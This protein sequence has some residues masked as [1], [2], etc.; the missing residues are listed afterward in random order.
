MARARNT[1]LYAGRP[2]KLTN[3]KPHR[4]IIVVVSSTRTPILHA[5]VYGLFRKHRTPK[6]KFVYVEWPE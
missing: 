6:P 4:T 1:E 5:Q 2:I 3:D